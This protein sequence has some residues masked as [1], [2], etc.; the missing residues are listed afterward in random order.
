MSRRSGPTVTLPVPRDRHRL[1]DARTPVPPLDGLFVLASPGRRGLW[2]TTK[3]LGAFG[4]PEL[5]TFEVSIEV[6]E[7]WAAVMRG[8]ARTLLERWREATRDPSLAFVEISTIV[9][10]TTALVEGVDEIE[11]PGH[12]PV[13]AVQ[14]RLDPSTDMR[15]DDFLTIG[16]PDGVKARGA[17]YVTRLCTELLSVH[18][19]EAHGHG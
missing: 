18:M 1:P 15:G 7:I 9:E 16:P 17:S 6:A 3:G 10:L 12:G 4:L 13:G 2:I 8:I 5:Q 14:L 19:H 11:H